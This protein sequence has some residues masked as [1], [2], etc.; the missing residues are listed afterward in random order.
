M[1]ASLTAHEMGTIKIVSVVN[2]TKG[3]SRRKEMFN[4][5]TLCAGVRF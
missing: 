2:D 4:N 1:L 3:L 5:F